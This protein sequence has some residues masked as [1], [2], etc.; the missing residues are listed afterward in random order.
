MNRLLKPNNTNRSEQLQFLRFI[1]FLLIF[2]WH[3][4]P[5]IPFK[6]PGTNGA[7][8]AVEFFILLSG[9]VSGFSSYGQDIEFSVKNTVSYMIHK[10]KKT[11]PLYLAVTL[12]S[13]TMTQ[14]P[15]YIAKGAYSDMRYVIKQLGKHLLLIQSWFPRGYFE[16]SRVGWFLSTIMFL[17]LLNIP[18][19]AVAGKI[20]KSAHPDLGFG[21]VA[22]GAIIVTVIYCYVLRGTNMEFTEYVLPVARTGEY[23]CG[24]AAGYL[25]YD[26][27]QKLTDRGISGIVYGV[28]EILILIIW[29]A[30]MYMPIKAWT[31]RIVHWMI[32][33][34]LL[35][36][37]FALGLGFVSRLFKNRILVFLGDISFECFLLHRMVI[38]TYTFNTGLESTNVV[39]DCFAIVFCLMVTITTATVIHKKA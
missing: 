35:I 30:A 10:L 16:F 19:R 13:V 28:A 12:F 8:C 34:L 24:M 11:Y 27:R 29:I 20:K 26:F 36:S 14:L 18:F 31:Y 2:I 33:N 9:F 21:L 22:L 6:F 7:A 38:D 17:Y 39:G 1:G 23:I 25:V 5:Y 4:D 37:V 3:M 32:P 15:A